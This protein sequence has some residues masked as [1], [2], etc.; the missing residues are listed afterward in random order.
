MSSVLAQASAARLEEGSTAAIA[1]TTA[2]AVAEASE[3]KAATKDNIRRTKL[4]EAQFELIG[5]FDDTESQSIRDPDRWVNEHRFTLRKYDADFEA[6]IRKFKSRVQEESK[7]L[8]EKFETLR[9]HVE[10]ALRTAVDA[11]PTIMMG[12]QPSSTAAVVGAA[13][14][15]GG[16]AST[17]K[18]MIFH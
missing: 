1:A 8:H 4:A 10:G 9:V 3:Q 14:Q 7:V 11:Q 6:M 16:G 5:L 18:S 15:E 2:A 17:T 13:R 12:K